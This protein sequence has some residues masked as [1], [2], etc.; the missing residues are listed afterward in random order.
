[1]TEALVAATLCSQLCGKSLLER[2]E[3]GCLQQ[4]WVV[5]CAN[6]AT[7]AA[8]AAAAIAT[9]WERIVTNRATRLRACVMS[10]SQL[11]ARALSLPLHSHERPSI[12]AAITSGSRQ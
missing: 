12:N 4:E 9:A 1:M 7:A 6:A 3:Q 11:V 5:G 8:A 10:S 2:C